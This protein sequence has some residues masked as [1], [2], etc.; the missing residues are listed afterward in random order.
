[1][2]NGLGE[3]VHELRQQAEKRARDMKKTASL[4]Q[5]LLKEKQNGK[6]KLFENFKK[7]HNTCDDHKLN[8]I[9]IEEHANKIGEDPEALLEEFEN[10]LKDESKKDVSTA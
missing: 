5:Q 1:M 8:I 3:D 10:R 9:W 4:Y 7:R 6:N 2:M